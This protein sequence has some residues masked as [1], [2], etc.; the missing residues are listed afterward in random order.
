MMAWAV[1]AACAPTNLMAQVVLEGR[2]TTETN[3]P[4]A[5]AR[6][7]A[8]SVV[9]SKILEA[10]SDPTGA[11]VLTLPEA[12]AYSLKIDREGFYIHSEPPMKI[13]AV[14]GEPP[15]ELH[16]VLQTIHEIT[17]S[18]DV[19]DQP[20]VVDMDR[21]APQTTLSSRTLYDVPFPNQSSLRSGLRLVPGVVQDS[22]GS[23]HLFG[24]A[25]AQVQYTFEGFEINDPL[26]GRLDA[27]M[28]LESVQSVDVTSQSGAESGRGEAGTMA[29][30][31]RT[32]DDKFKFSATSIFPGIDTGLGVRVGS[33]TPRGDFSGPWLKG[34]AWFFG[35]TELNY[36]DTVIP[37]L[38]AGQDHSISW[39]VNSLLHNQIN[40][41]PRNILFIGL[42]F[43]YFFAPRNGL[44]S[45]DPL[46]TTVDRRSNQ[47][48]G[49]IK[50]QHSFSRSSLIEF[51]FAASR[52]FTREVPQGDLP[53][54]ITPSGRMG[55][56]YVN[57]RRVGER[58][59]A[60]T[61]F[62]LPPFGFLGTHQFKAGADAV[63]LDY[64]QNVQRDPIDYMGLDGTIVRQ[65]NFIG[66]GVL[67]RANFENSIYLQ[68]A[69]KI[70]QK[71]L[72]ELGLRADHDLILS[73]WNTSP[74]AG[75]AWSP[76][77]WES[78]RFSGG[79][80]T[81]YNPTD[82]ALF[83]RPLDQYTTSTYF[84]PDGSVASGPVASV[85][86][87]GTN[88]Q[89]PRATTW[90]LG[91][92]RE[93]PKLIQGKIQLLRRHSTRGFSYVN[94]LGANGGLP[95]GLNL[96]TVLVPLGAI[97]EL[98]NQREDTYDSVEVAVRQPLKGRFEWMVSYT[99]S[100]ALSNAVLDHSIDQPLVIADNSGPL[101]WD[102]PNRLLSWGYLPTW[103][104]NWAVAYL[105]D[106][107]SGFP[108][109]VQDQY[110][111]LVGVVDDHRFKQ[112]FELNVF[113]ER[114]LILR[115]YR[116][117]VRAG[118]NNITGHFNPNVIDNVVGGPT[119]LREYGGQSRSLN[120]QVRYLGRQ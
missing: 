70:R 93:F 81:I 48:F 39:R 95:A 100:R 17:S 83:T 106:S 99:R 84:N 22:S 88:V 15:A 109:S 7:T 8:E 61:D 33:W 96:P 57:A 68:D 29:F 107:H 55:N 46:S 118:F 104:K 74:R 78:T 43:N 1:L 38:P 13:P 44:T 50:D 71:L 91:A 54:L 90:N 20:G 27:R 41:S 52:T 47:W 80:A 32:G 60:L 49:Y 64:A 42:L 116:L 115:S 76:P 108:F 65:V 98:T 10:T 85:Y 82:L 75:F 62:Y 36:T 25:E 59:Q 4:V 112:F 103:W 2:V 73:H 69:W 14:V 34:R 24:G 101:P 110:G 26:T 72:I 40:L 35:T 31:A 58:Q 5:G 105:L 67:S 21:T 3:A 30:H 11:F 9:L 51:G 86:T 28:S 111:Q 119:Y 114:Q 79:V 97:Y 45:L 66:S 23:L 18:V 102:V 77:G 16:V 113:V 56:N 53:Y 120:F 94:D 117:A 63:H 12:G 19:T 92:Q 87:A 89:T 6:I 37:Q